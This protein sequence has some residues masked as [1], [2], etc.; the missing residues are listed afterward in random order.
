[1]QRNVLIAGRDARRRNRIRAHFE[2]RGYQ[3]A[4]AGDTAQ[5]IRRLFE[6]RPILVII[7]THAEP[8]QG[9]GWKLCRWIRGITT[10]PLIILTASSDSGAHIKALK[11]GADAALDWPIDLEELY[12]RAVALLRR[13]GS[14]SERRHTAS[15]T[16][17]DSVDKLVGDIWIDAE[18]RHVWVQGRAA[19][20]TPREFQLL[21][22]LVEN[23]GRVVPYKEIQEAVWGNDAT[24]Q[25]VVRQFVSQL[26]KK[27]EED[28]TNPRYIRTH[29]GIGYKLITS[30]N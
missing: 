5:G 22:Y 7:D 8:P 3:V 30:T 9:E 26:R 6:C 11:L 12:L 24:G 16:L 21:T 17:V 25:W 15:T 2:A 14:P 19:V 28:P 29:R 27:I 1:M 18:R 23:A 13:V 4:T 20:L 10:V